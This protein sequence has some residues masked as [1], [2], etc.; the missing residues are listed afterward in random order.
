MSGLIRR[1][2]LAVFL[3]ILL[4][5]AIVA[6]MLVGVDWLE[7]P[8]KL[9]STVKIVNARVVDESKLQA[10]LKKLED[11][12]KKKLDAEVAVRKE[13]EKRLADLKKR[14][15]V[16]QKRLADLERKRLETEKQQA[17]KLAEL[18]KKQEA[19]R[20]KLEEMKNT[21]DLAE[22]V[23]KAKAQAAAE[24]K[25][26][27]DEARKKAEAEADKL[28][29]AAAKKAE[30]EK[31]RQAAIAKAEAEKAARQQELEERLEAEQDATELDLLTRQIQ[32]KVTQNW[33]RPPGTT[34]L[35]CTVRV[36][37]G[38]S[39]SVLLVQVIISSGNG[40]FDRSVEAA[41]RKSEPL[42]M[43]RSPR[44]LAQFRELTFL[45]DPS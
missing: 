10:E 31:K 19:E 7:K 29:K 37:L 32:T 36:R 38:T 30:A 8:K 14:R 5:I 23:R 13:E 34:G 27:A 18:K 45:F 41:V 12:K 1:N 9:A 24:R 42:P 21:R 35:K 11:A 39:G 26:K 22:K 6:F 44:L 17:K 43:P 28:R 16:E 15:D 2:P 25:K 4:H 33:I 40:S 20:K 3:A